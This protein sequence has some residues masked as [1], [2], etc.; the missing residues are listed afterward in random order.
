[1]NKTGAI[2][3]TP[4]SRDFQHSDVYV[5]GDINPTIPII[6][7]T[8]PKLT[9]MDQDPFGDCPCYDVARLMKAWWFDKGLGELDLSP[10]FLV[11]LSKEQDGIPSSQGTYPRI[12]MG[13]AVNIGCCTQALL[14]DDR[15]LSWEEYSNPS[16][17][18]PEMTAE[19]L[20]YRV[21][22]YITIPS[23][24]TS[25]R[26]AL[27]Q[28]NRVGI[29]VP[30]GNFNT[31]VLVP[32]LPTAQTEFHRI[33]LYGDTPQNGYELDLICNQWGKT[34]GN[35]GFGAFRF[36][37]FSGMIYDVMAF[38]EITPA[39][40]KMNYLKLHSVGTDV[41]TLQNELIKAGYPLTA[42][43]VFGPQTD[44]SLRDFQSKNGLSV[45][46]VVGP[47]TQAKLQSF[48]S[49]SNTDPLLNAVIQVESG[50]NDNAVGDHG[51]AFGCLQMWQ[52]TVDEV[53]IKLGTSHVAH[54]TLGNRSLSILIWNTYWQIH[55]E[56][57]T[58]QDKAFCWN[59]GSGWKQR[60][61]LP[62]WKFY[63]NNLDI[64]WSNVQKYL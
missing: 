35:S 32:P 30:V 52:G 21:P 26:Q 57:V 33:T 54:E 3:N 24:L 8:I 55:T 18:T 4:D 51:N 13:I 37:D 7:T 59:G 63:S 47:N 9:I 34:W 6:D 22:A 45:D 27:T 50:G 12:P 2:L 60:Y 1:M 58:D 48:A 19:A 38:T 42:D 16:V 43:G 20:K 31:S 15:T 49:Q 14:P 5:A 56:M 36:S 40:K 46:G 53:N 29:T 25:L 11:I 61:G 44:N 28:Y 41:T 39:I 62:Q 17:I 23:D 64:Y 10:R